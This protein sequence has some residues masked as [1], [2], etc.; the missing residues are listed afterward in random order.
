VSR[1]FMK[2]IGPDLEKIVRD[3][4][5]RRREALLHLAAR[6]RRAREEDLGLE[7]RRADPAA[8]RRAEALH[9]R[10]HQVTESI[11]AGQPVVKAEYDAL[12]AAAQRHRN[13]SR[14]RAAVWDLA[15]AELY[16]DDGRNG[17]KVQ[18][19]GK[20]PSGYLTY[21]RDGRMV[22]ILVKEGRTKLADISKATEKERVE[23]FNTMIAYAGRSAWRAT[24][25]PITS[26]SPGTSLDR[27]RAGRNITLEG[28]KLF[29]RSD[30]QARGLTAISRPSNWNGRSWQ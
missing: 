3:V 23:L 26:I 11:L 25:S 7:R 27:H 30:G 20:R 24:E 17:Q 15:A 29:I 21:S 8:A 19:F 14:A 6:R 1:S 5:A 28:R 9:R 10:R 13:R 16:P 18:A 2:Q 4:L 22:G 12:R